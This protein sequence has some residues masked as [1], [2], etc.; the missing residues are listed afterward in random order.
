MKISEIIYREEYIMSEACEDTGFSKISTPPDETNDDDLLIIP[1]SKKVWDLSNIKVRPSAVICDQNVILPDYIPRIVVN[2]PRLALANA[3]YRYE[4]IDL[5]DM[6]II[7]ITGTN[8][9]TTTA[10]LIKN[11]LSDCGY[12]VGFIGTGKIEIGSKNITP[13]NYSMTTPDP[14]MLYH[15]LKEMERQKCNAVVMEV[16]SHSLALDKLAPLEF[17]YA[18]FTNLSPEHLDF[19]GDM[20]SYFNAKMKLFKK[21]KCSIFN[22]DDEYVNRAHSLC[23]GKKI[24]A[25][26]LWRGDVFASNLENHGVNGISYT[27]HGNG[28]SFKMNL[29]IAGIYNAYNSMLAA[30]LCVEMGCKPCEVKKTLSEISPVNGRYEIIND[31]ISVIIDYAHTAEAFKCILSELSSIKGK[32]KLT[33]VFGC[34]GDRDKSKRPEMAK[35]AE[36]Y[37]DRIILTADNSRS[38]NTKDIIADIIKGFE[39]GNYEIKENREDAI[40]SAILGANNSDVVAIIGKG[41][42]KYNI[43]KTGYHHF[44]EREIIKSAL[45]KRNSGSGYAS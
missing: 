38:E 10:T 14:S 41:P 39:C 2:N 8:G 33:V 26:I 25:G 45:N 17:D 34:G 20:E 37:A 30:A 29:P 3:Y 12:K 1:N 21:S 9:K 13:T 36:K 28:F 7:G 6:K 22:I 27:Y 35:I 42:E 31:K 11:I 43:D 44:D 5:K 15:T 23:T 18:V 16:S 4:K 24:S 40:Y 19:H 32:G